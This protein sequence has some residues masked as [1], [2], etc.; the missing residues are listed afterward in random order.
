MKEN[1]KL[2]AAI[3]GWIITQVTV[4]TTLYIVLF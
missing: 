4:I 3:V 1:N 2:E